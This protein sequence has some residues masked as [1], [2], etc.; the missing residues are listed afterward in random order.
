MALCPRPVDDADPLDPTAA[1]TT[2]DEAFRLRAAAPSVRLLHGD[3]GRLPGTARIGGP[4][5]AGIHAKDLAKPDE[6]RQP[7]H[8]Y[9]IAPGHDAWVLG[10][11]PFVAVEFKS[12]G[13][14]AKS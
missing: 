6:V 14:C 9:R 7:G 4:G 3:S 12:A 1:I 8:A 10:D 2:T 13:S 5:M 11:E